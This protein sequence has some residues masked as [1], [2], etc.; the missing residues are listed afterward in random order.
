MHLCTRARTRVCVWEGGE[1]E[2]VDRFK[3]LGSLVEVR[4]EVVGEVG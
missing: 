2:V 1:V 3:Y 4:G